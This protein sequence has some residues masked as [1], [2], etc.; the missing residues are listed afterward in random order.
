MGLTCQNWMRWNQKKRALVS[1]LKSDGL[2]MVSRGGEHDGLHGTRYPA[3][4]RPMEGN[5]R[6]AGESDMHP[7][8]ERDACG[9]LG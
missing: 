6:G 3:A 1:S 8:G 2:E 4:C 7:T 5:V 9:Q